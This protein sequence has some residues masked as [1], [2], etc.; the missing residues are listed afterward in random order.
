M[1]HNLIYGRSTCRI[2][3]ENFLN[4]ITSVIR[5]LDGVREIVIVHPNSTIS[6]LNIISF[7]WW[8]SNN[9][10]VNDHTDRPN[11]NFIR[12]SLFPFKNLWS[13][14]IWCTTNSSFTFAIIF[15]LCGKTEVSYFYF[16]L[17]IQE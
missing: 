9:K 12:M 1:I 6:C 16:H 4:K 17:I 15:E 8:L 11:I 14:I 5:N 3:I 13:D 10:G 7:K 2:I